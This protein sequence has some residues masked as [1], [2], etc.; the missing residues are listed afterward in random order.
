M[1]LHTFGNK[2]QQFYGGKGSFFFE[3]LYQ[4][5]NQQAL[6][7]FFRLWLHGK[8]FSGCRFGFRSSGGGNGHDQCLFLGLHLGADLGAQGDL[9][10]LL[11][12]PGELFF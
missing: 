3:A 8:G 2:I 1:F 12:F 7:P 6:A 5:V 4:P 11:L 10:R 9:L